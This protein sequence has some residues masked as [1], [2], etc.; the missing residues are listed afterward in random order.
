M[1]MIDNI[2]GFGINGVNKAKQ[3]EDL[4]VLETSFIKFYG[5]TESP[6]CPPKGGFCFKKDKVA[7]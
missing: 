2:R 6:D 7:V 1:T 5:E 4:I 3:Y